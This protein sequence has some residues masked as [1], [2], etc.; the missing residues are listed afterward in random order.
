[1]LRGKKRGIFLYILFFAAPR[2]HSN[3]G[4]PPG[5]LDCC[6]RALSPHWWKGEHSGQSNAGK[7]ENGDYKDG[8]GYKISKWPPRRPSLAERSWRHRYTKQGSIVSAR[9]DR[10]M[11]PPATSKTRERVR[12]AK[13]FLKWDVVWFPLWYVTSELFIINNFY[14]LITRL[15]KH[16]DEYRVLLKVEQFIFF[17]FLLPP[18]SKYWIFC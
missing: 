16:V 8:R 17:F 5:R 18:S 11:R 2:A 7:R 10:A 12:V 3:W 9:R 6:W 1:M 15:F 13:K 14:Q 4:G